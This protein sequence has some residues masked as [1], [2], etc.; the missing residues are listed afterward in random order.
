MK[1]TFFYNDAKSSKFW[2][3]E[4]NKNEFTVTYGKIGTLGQSQKKVFDNEESC[5]KEAEKLIKEKTKKNYVE[6]LTIDT[7]NTVVET[8]EIRQEKEKNQEKIKNNNIELNSSISSTDNTNITLYYCSG[9]SDK[10]YHAELLQ[11]E[12]GDGY[13]VNVAWGRRGSTLQTASKTVKP[14]S[15]E[16]AKAIYDKLVNEKMS[17]GYSPG[18]DGALFV[19]TNNA[20]RISGLL[21]QLLNAVTEEMVELLI[22]DPLYC[23]QPKHDG[24]R[25]MIKES[26]TGVNRKGLTVALP[27]HL[28]VNFLE[29]INGIA[30]LD[31]EMVG[32]RYTVFDI[33]TLN[34]NDMRQLPLSERLD[35]LNKHIKPNDSFGIVATAF[36]AQEKRELFQQ[37]KAANQEGIVFKELQAPYTHGRPNSGGP[38]LKYKFCESATVFVAAQNEG[39]RSVVMGLIDHDGTPVEVGSVTIS[40]N[41][42]IPEVGAIIEVRYLYA[43]PQGS[44]YQPV[45]GGMRQDMDINDCSMLQLKYKAT[46]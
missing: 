36:T 15:L 2:S 32:D 40:S 27:Q 14:L 19:D 3:I 11:A 31:G 22:N 6:N 44:L 46:N 29:N 16:K 12:S 25:R 35:I 5:E 18:E 41:F 8:V 30:D 20:G 28:A 23:A 34:G 17:K 37:L 10:V 43:Y 26:Q 45:Y 38:Q 24:E 7:A 13:L 33:M 42:A 21:P 39:K 9:S 1:R 4:T